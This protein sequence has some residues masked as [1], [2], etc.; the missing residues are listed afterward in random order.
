[1]TIIE[2]MY[3]GEKLNV[4]ELCLLATEYNKYCYT[5]PGNLM[6]QMKQN[7]ALG[8]G[9]LIW[10]LLLELEMIYGKYLGNKD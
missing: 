8:D 7:M 6:L 3:A 10:V 1:M 4:E 2:K 5:K 9:L